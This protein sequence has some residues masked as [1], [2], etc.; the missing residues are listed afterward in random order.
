MKMMTAVRTARARVELGD[1]QRATRFG[2]VITPPDPVDCG[3]LVLSPERTTWLG[4]GAVHGGVLRRDGR[5]TYA[6]AGQEP[7]L[8]VRKDRVEWLEEGGRSITINSS[9]NKARRGSKVT[10]SG[11]IDGG[12]A[13][14]ASQ[15]VKIK[16][17]RP[18]GG[19]W[20]TVAADSTNGSG[21]YSVKERVR[22]TKQY[23]AIAPKNG[24]CNKA[25][26]KT[27]KVRVKR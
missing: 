11:R 6:N 5:M 2:V 17:R 19:K 14:A 4:A 25:R 23:R 20:R 21:Q 18:N 3:V 8:V 7:P 1:G 13:C 26:S 15:G 9:R 16:A 27:I 22:K 10:F 24:P 12:D